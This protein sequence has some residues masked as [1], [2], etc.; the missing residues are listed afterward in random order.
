MTGRHYNMVDR[1]LAK[2]APSLWENGN[3]EVCGIMF[4]IPFSTVDVRSGV[5]GGRRRVAFPYSI[6][7][8][9]GATQVVITNIIPMQG[10]C[11]FMFRFS[12]PITRFCL[13]F[14]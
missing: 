13:F 9:S 6:D 14:E 1:G 11:I 4:V 3:R 8:V 5:G 12:F 7:N 2:A 10:N